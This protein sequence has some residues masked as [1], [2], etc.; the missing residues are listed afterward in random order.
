MNKLL[1]EL[2]FLFSFLITYSQK[3]GYYFVW[4]K[5]KANNSFTLSKPYEFLS[6]RTI[7]KRLLYNIYFD[8][9]DLPVSNFYINQIEN[10][11]AYF[12]SASKWLNGGI[13]KI[14]DS[15][16]YYNISNLP[17]VK[18]ITYL[19]PLTTEAKIFNK[20][21]YIK[22][23]LL[24]GCAENQIKMLKG[25]FLHN[26]GFT[27]D[28]ILIAVLD[29][30]FL[31]ANK[32][33]QFKH[34]FDNE[35]IKLTR[36]IIKGGYSTEVFDYHFH[37]T[38]VLSIIA[39][40]EEGKYIGSA[41]NADFVL[42]LTEDAYTEYLFEEY[43]WVIGAEIADSIGADIINSSLGYTIFDDP[44]QN[45]TWQDLDGKT[46]V[47]SIAANIC[48][49]KGILVVSSAGNLRQT[50]WIK[51]SVP[52]DA[53]SILTVG[54]VD[55]LGNL[56]PFSS[57]GNTADGR[58]KPTIVAQGYHAC[59]INTEGEQINCS[60]TSF[61]APLISGLSACLWQP[62]KDSINNIDIYNVI[63]KSSNKYYNPDSL[64]G[65]GLPNFQLA[66]YM[67]SSIKKNNMNYPVLM[68][69][70][71]KDKFYV[72]FP[73]TNSIKSI[74]IYNI[75]GKVMYNENF[76]EN[77]LIID[78]SHFSCGIYFVSI[79]IEEKIYNYKIIKL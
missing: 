31:N 73:N 1:I 70:P 65:Y 16:I 35:K 13:F 18:K 23:N 15:I 5:D 38:M 45:H 62:F 26:L 33:S 24:Y 66:F 41:P 2:L 39:S 22:N 36:N 37:G 55:S 54:A 59:C 34:L 74:S 63:I 64:Y 61:S 51:I 76:F 11:G 30:G 57:T 53:D 44:S 8:S 75:Y 79:T 19:K 60:G 56:A 72:K 50:N 17:F 6:E 10:N 69:N 32:I 14:I 21:L 4:F 46:A 28:S 68:K 7:K 58:I 49:R 71:V 42:L 12:H 27:G 43:C 77:F 78:I 67:L 25:D 29:A 52:A 48:A 9:L 40:Q 3:P 47:A 20:E